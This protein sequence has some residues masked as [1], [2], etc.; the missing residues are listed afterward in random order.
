MNKKEL[1]ETIQKI[2][3]PNKITYLTI[4]S[5]NITVFLTAIYNLLETDE[6]FLIQIEGLI[7]SGLSTTAI[8]VILY[9]YYKEY[10]PIKTKTKRRN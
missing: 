2:S 3:I 9:G 5:I 10:L 1:K 8:I 4:E 7:A 6:N